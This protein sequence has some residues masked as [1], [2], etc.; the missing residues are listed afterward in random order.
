VTALLEVRGLTKRF[1]GLVALDAVD[2]DVERGAIKGLIGPNGAGKT[3][4]FNVV[5]GFL[6]PDAGQVTLEGRALTGLPAH[7]VAQRGLART[8]QKVKLFRGMSVLEHVMVGCHH[9]GR[10]EF[11]GAMLTPGWVRAEERTIRD[12]ALE[13]LQMVGLAAR[14]DEPAVTMPFG[15]QRLLELARALALH[16]AVLLMDEPAAGLNTYET[17]A[18]A[19]L[20]RSLPDRQVTVVLVEH[21]MTLVMGVCH[22]ITV[23]N[24]G[25]KIA[26]GS[27]AEVQGDRGVIDAY[28]GGELTADA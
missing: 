11:L 4:F 20:I 2:H 1:G 13:M 19:A 24:F 25:R 28:L 16:P 23:L 5:T 10:A 12:E 14:A 3:T 7:L 15:Q 9:R 6:A 21:N 18:L 17:E 8:F 22:E 26:D 27:P